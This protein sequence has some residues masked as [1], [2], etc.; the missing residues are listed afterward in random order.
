MG[1]KF[2]ESGTAARSSIADLFAAGVGHQLGVLPEALATYAVSKGIWSPA[3]QD[4]L[5]EQAM[6]QPG[7][8][9]AKA[10]MGLAGMARPASTIGAAY[11]T[12]R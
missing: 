3:V 12:N 2:P 6:R 10:A 11:S 5:V 9:R 8:T 7:P 4:F 1:N